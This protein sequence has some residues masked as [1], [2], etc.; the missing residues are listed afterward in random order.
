MFPC[1]RLCQSFST[2]ILAGNTPPIVKWLGI[3]RVYRIHQG[4]IKP[5]SPSSLHNNDAVKVLTL[6]IYPFL[7]FRLVQHN[8]RSSRGEPPLLISVLWTSGVEV[9]H[10]H[11][12]LP[13]SLTEA[14]RLHLQ[15]A[16]HRAAADQVGPQQVTWNLHKRSFWDPPPPARCLSDPTETS[17]ATTTRKAQEVTILSILW[18]IMYRVVFFY[19]SALKMT[20]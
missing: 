9:L 12:R 7:I 1:T 11:P 3:T 5:H 10:H 8:G 17:L 16:V 15:D 2:E 13:L 6:G 20:Y 14:P 4:P 19:C 18:T